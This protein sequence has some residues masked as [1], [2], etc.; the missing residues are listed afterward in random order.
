MVD[1]QEMGTSSVKSPAKMSPQGEIVRQPDPST[2]EIKAAIKEALQIDPQQPASTSTPPAV[3]LDKKQ[4]TAQQP[5]Q[6][7]VA[8]ITLQL[9]DLVFSLEEQEDTEQSSKSDSSSQDDTLIEKSVEETVSH[10]VIEPTK[11]NETTVAGSVHTQELHQ[12]EPKQDLTQHDAETSPV[13]R[14]AAEEEDGKPISTEKPSDP[15]ALLSPTDGIHQGD[16]PFNQPLSHA[17]PRSVTRRMSLARL[18]TRRRTA[19]PE[20]KIPLSPG[21]HHSY[22]SPI[23]A[24][25]SKI[26]ELSPMTEKSL[27]AHL[28]LRVG[29]RRWREDAD[30]DSL[31]CY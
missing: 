11:T 20:L 4:E 22:V 29:G 9:P 15:P 12:N 19:M 3:V 7:K 13:E 27:E 8:A 14:S 23:S 28:A 21:S 1:H 31:Y 24:S 17:Q 6:E 5:A 26:S 10:E 16:K 30:T 2:V 25:S 18:F